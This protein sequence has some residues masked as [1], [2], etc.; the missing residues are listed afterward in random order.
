MITKT[1]TSKKGAKVFV[2]MVAPY[3]QRRMRAG[4]EAGASGD[5]SGG[6]WRRK[7]GRVETEAGTCLFGTVLAI[8]ICLDFGGM[9]YIV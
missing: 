3:L 6:E 9:R 8:A 2:I 4:V 5:G 1:F 7:R